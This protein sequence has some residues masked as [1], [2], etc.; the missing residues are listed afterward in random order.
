MLEVQ[1]KELMSKYIPSIEGKEIKV[2][3]LSGL[4]N[5]TYAVYVDHAPLYVFKVFSDG[6]DRE[7]ENKV[8]Q[9]LSDLQLSPNIIHAEKTFRI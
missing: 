6:F 4:T 2:Q 9:H 1:I 7:T 3:R 8:V 5:V